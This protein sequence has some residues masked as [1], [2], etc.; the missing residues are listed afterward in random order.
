MSPTHSN[1]AIIRDLEIMA[2]SVNYRKWIFSCISQHVGNRVIELGGGIGSFTK[3]LT[4][5]ELV[6]VVDNHAPAIEYI[7]ESLGGLRNVVPLQMDVSSDEML[8]LGKY[9]ADTIVCINVL[10]HIE[11][12]AMAL[13][14]MFNILREGGKLSLLVPAFPFLYGSIDHVLGHYR[15]YGKKELKSKLEAAGFRILCLYFIN[16]L[17]VPAWFFNNRIRKIKEES[18]A[19]VL[20]FDKYIVPWLRKVERIVRPPFGLSLI[21]ICE[22]H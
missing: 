1:D 15:R 22:K 7:K 6:V 16:F 2:Q 12:D 5:R 8:G 18:P 4:D 13:S 9:E 17:A 11:D 3:M 21:A 10:E 19:Q 14:N 20:I